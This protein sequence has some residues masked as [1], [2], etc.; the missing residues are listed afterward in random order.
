MGIQLFQRANNSIRLTETGEQLF[1]QS[2]QGVQ[3]LERAIRAAMDG[4]GEVSVKVPVTLA[5]RW[6]IPGLENFHSRNRNIRVRIE[7][8]NA[9]G[10]DDRSDVDVAIAYHPVGA[11]PSH[12]E[13]LFEDRCRPYLSPSLLTKVDVVSELDRIPALQCASANW[14]WLLWLEGCGRSSTTLTYVGHFDLDDTALRAAIAGIGMVL[15]SEFLVRDD[16]AAG[17]LCPL[18]EADEVL[19]GAYTVHR[20]A[21]ASRQTEK[22]LLWLDEHRKRSG[23]LT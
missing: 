22:F 13:I 19:L 20:P 9:I 10:T 4:T 11:L 5:T 16:V 1:R 3:S 17:R 15:A 8:T 18:P 21:P 7:T 2:M 14:D 23:H 12:A 6:L